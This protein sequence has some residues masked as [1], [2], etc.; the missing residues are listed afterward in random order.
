MR[1]SAAWL[2]IFFLSLAINSQARPAG[3]ST[4]NKR[5]VTIK[6]KAHADL[7]NYSFRLIEG[8]TG[9]ARIEIRNEQSDKIIQVLKSFDLE[10]VSLLN[11][12]D[13]KL[14]D[15]NFDGYLDLE[16]LSS[17]GTAGEEYNFW[18]FNKT[19][20]KFVFNKKLSELQNPRFNHKTKTIKAVGIIGR[21]GDDYV[22]DFYQFENGKLVMVREVTQ[23]LLE[24]KD[25]FLREIY[26]R[27]NGRM[28]LVRKKLSKEPVY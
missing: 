28:V 16:L 1:R 19:S 20:G 3:Q 11:P 2:L 8:D 7:P 27:K 12:D 22:K 24:K 10:S 9:E 21:L 6:G 14:E 26:V 17:R 15:V 5:E 13:F 18:L 25:L 23:T 4:A